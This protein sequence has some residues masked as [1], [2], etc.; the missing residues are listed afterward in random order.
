MNRIK[1]LR[2]MKKITITELS[3]SLDIPQSTLTNYENGKRTPRDQVTWKKL[4]DYFDVPIAYIMGLSDQ[5]KSFSQIDR[6]REELLNSFPNPDMYPDQQPTKG[7]IEQ[8]WNLTEKAAEI[9][10]LDKELSPDTLLNLA[11]TSDYTRTLIYNYA[12]L[13][14]ENKRLA[15]NYI[16]KLKKE[17]EEDSKFSL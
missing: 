12:R 17:Q 8:F 15:W 14:D 7:Q 3:E 2:K 6:E 10:E 1:E 16:M 11:K 5:K 4:A 13:N 9:L